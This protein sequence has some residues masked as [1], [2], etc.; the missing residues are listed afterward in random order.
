MSG[1]TLDYISISGFKSIAA[2]E[3][4]HLRPINIL[5]GPNGSG[6]SNF[7]GAFSFMQKIQEGELT[8]YVKRAG[9][10]DKVL[11]FGSKASPE[12]Y[13][14]CT[15]INGGHFTIRLGPTADDSLYLIP[16]LKVVHKAAAFFEAEFPEGGD[17]IGTRMSG[18]RVYH[19]HDTSDSS[20]MRKTA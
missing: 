9:G 1:N 5:I 18:W 8:D 13:L 17:F 14:R 11:H 10:A 2:I 15:F 4:L 19:L 3:R 20:L 12:I 7:I 6:K 16:N